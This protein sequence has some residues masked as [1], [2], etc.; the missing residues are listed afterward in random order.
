[1]EAPKRLGV[2]R[3]A[4][5]N[6]RSDQVAG[7]AL[8]IE[9]IVHGPSDVLAGWLG[10]VPPRAIVEKVPGDAILWCNRA[11]GYEIGHASGRVS[12]RVSEY[13]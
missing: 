7:A 12:T 3:S 1:M 6:S 11:P 10:G 4:A 5:P 2:K 9:A 13:V 8:L